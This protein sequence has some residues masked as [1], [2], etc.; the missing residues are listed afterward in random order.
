MNPAI[1]KEILKKYT[2]LSN[3]KV[4]TIINILEKL[5][6]TKSQYKDIDYLMNQVDNIIEMENQYNN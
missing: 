5:E 2:E 4:I 6:F 3:D 1:K